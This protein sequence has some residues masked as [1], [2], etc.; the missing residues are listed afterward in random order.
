M[1]HG[2]N[3]DQYGHEIGTLVRLFSQ[4]TESQ[5]ERFLGVGEVS[6]ELKLKPKR[7]ICTEDDQ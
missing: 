6:D 3:V 5:A 4:A 7:L 2:Q 1:L